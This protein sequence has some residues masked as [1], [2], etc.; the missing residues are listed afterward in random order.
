MTESISPASS[1]NLILSAIEL[2]VFNEKNSAELARWLIETEPLQAKALMTP[3]GALAGRVGRAVLAKG[4]PT[5]NWSVFAFGL[6]ST[7]GRA[8]WLPS[9]IVSPVQL[10]S[11]ALSA[12]LVASL[13]TLCVARCAQIL[14]KD[15]L[16]YSDALSDGA[17]HLGASLRLGRHLGAEIQ[18]RI[19]N[20][21]K[22]SLSASTAAAICAERVGMR[23]ASD[24]LAD[25]GRS[26]KLRK[27]S[28]NDWRAGAAVKANLMVNH[29]Q[30]TRACYRDA[31]RLLLAEKLGHFSYEKPVAGASPEQNE[32]LRSLGAD[33]DDRY[34]QSA[35]SN[36]QANIRSKARI[37][38]FPCWAQQ[39]LATA[40]LNSASAS[41]APV[42]GMPTLAEVLGL[43]VLAS[44]VKH[45]ANLN[46]NHAFGFSAESLG[47]EFAPWQSAIEAQALERS[48]S[49]IS[50]PLAQSKFSSTDPSMG[51]STV[52]AR[53]SNRI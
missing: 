3:A 25:I 17:G 36:P 46:A 7:I 23:Q 1:A 32:L 15:R 5:L 20:F 28:F 40:T 37:L 41:Y 49:Q 4:L 22:I 45:G 10:T 9:S 12:A 2:P 21:H 30:R 52:S 24:A 31:L 38:S 47:S 35:P 53:R 16:T 26:L 34:P 48:L 51:S 8:G 39:A 11:L 14:V 33:F 42:Q 13:G 44:N 6:A 19:P 29:G 27:L 43:L 50:P 18:S